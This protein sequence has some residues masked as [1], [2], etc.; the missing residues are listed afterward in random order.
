MS[1]N[2]VSLKYI[3]S[4]SLRGPTKRAVAIWSWDAPLTQIAEF[5]LS[6]RER[7]VPTS[8]DSSQ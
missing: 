7:V 4:L 8:L 2:V 6:E 3:H 1:P 5:T